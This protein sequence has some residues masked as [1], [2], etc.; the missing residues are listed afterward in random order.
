[1]NECLL[2][3]LDELWLWHK[4]TQKN[5]NELDKKKAG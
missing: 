1:M 3:V 2:H 4:Q 5:S